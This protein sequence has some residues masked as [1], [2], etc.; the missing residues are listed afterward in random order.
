MQWQL[1]VKYSQKF[2]QS[3]SA[4]GQVSVD[5]DILE[6]Q[7]MQKGENDRFERG[8]VLNSYVDLF[9][10][11][12]SAQQPCT[13]IFV[14]GNARSGKAALISTIAHHWATFIAIK[15]VFQVNESQG[16]LQI[17]QAKLR[18]FQYVFVIS[19]HGIRSGIALIRCNL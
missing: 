2:K 19:F 15:G 10:I 16:E 17:L 9:T 18:R 4:K 3:S 6:L 7:V 8:K 14:H 12:G 5:Q 13:H 11:Q 1:Q